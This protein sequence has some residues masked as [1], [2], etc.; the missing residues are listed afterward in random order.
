M[1]EPVC[2][3]QELL[4][5]N[6]INQHKHRGTSYRLL[7][8]I[9][10]DLFGYKNVIFCFLYT[11][12]LI[13]QKSMQQIISKA[14]WNLMLLFPGDKQDMAQKH[15]IKNKNQDYF[16]PTWYGNLT[17]VLQ[18]ALLLQ[19]CCFPHIIPEL[20][21]SIATAWRCRK[22][23][24]STSLVCYVSIRGLQM[25]S[26]PSAT[27]FGR[28][29]HSSAVWVT[30]CCILRDFRHFRRIASLVCSKTPCQSWLSLLSNYK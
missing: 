7:K 24:A 19:M 8:L 17:L 4:V 26:S 12:V 30:T 11:P 27:F 16:L 5:L 18:G 15:R 20:K 22:L 9:Q 2:E 23:L 10:A 21:G 28:Y 6:H 13:T 3:V 1:S 25:F 29:S 14:T